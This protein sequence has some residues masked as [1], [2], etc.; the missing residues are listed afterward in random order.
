VLITRPADQAEDLCRLVAQAGGRPL[1]FPTIAIAPGPDPGAARALLARPWDLLLF[2]SRNAVD[3]ALPLFPGGR[4]PAGPTLAA[5][6]AATAAALT[7]AG[8]PPD[9]VPS[10]RFDSGE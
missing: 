7:A 2:V 9:L 3:F 6:G 5:V 10:D 4:P 8:R 1:R